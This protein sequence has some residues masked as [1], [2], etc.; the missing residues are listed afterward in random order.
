MIYG[1]KPS[2][3]NQTQIQVMA[4]NHQVFGVQPIGHKNEVQKDFKIDVTSNEEPMVTTDTSTVN[5]VNEEKSCDKSDKIKDKIKDKPK[6][7]TK[8][9]EMRK[10]RK[11]HKIMKREKCDQS[12]AFVLMTEQFKQKTIKNNQTKSLEQ[13]LTETEKMVNKRHELKVCLR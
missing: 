5:N 9:K 13:Y 11:L 7:K 2:K 8:A 6:N 1:E 10:D 12:T 3:T 4:D